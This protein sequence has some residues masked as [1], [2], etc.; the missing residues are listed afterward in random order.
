MNHKSL[1]C[2][3]S[4][5]L[6]TGCAADL[7]PDFYQESDV[8]EAVI[9]KRGVILDARTVTIGGKKKLG[10]NT[11]GLIGG[12]L[13]GGIAG[14]QIGAGK[15]SVLAALGGAGLGA[16]GGTFLE[17]KLNEQKGIEYTVELEGTKELL[18][19]TQGA[20]AYAVGTVVKV[21]MPRSNAHGGSR[22]RIIPFGK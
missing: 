4:L 20:P 9:T 10:D 3:C 21:T 6:L 13:A 18:T 5:F 2:F 15:G 8:G 11:M 19:V 1:A 22:A 7:S 16:L 12:G 17:K 14:S